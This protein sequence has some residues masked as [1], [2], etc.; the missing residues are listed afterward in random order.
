MLIL[1]S[2]FL[3]PAVAD[4]ALA[5]LTLFRM[6]GVT[7]DS[8]I[9]RGEFAGVA[10]C[11]AVLLLVGYKKPVERAWILGPT[12][13]VIG[14]IGAA[15]LLGFM[16]GVVSALRVAFVLMLCAALIWLCLAGLQRARNTLSRPDYPPTGSV[17]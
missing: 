9:P 4:F 7:D 15:F 16:V 14:C 11:W 3:A 13:R 8:L 2:A 5:F 10:F 1:R 12:A 17:P 6:I